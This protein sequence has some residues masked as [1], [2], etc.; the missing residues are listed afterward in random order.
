MAT[1]GVDLGGT[2]IMAVLVDDGE[3]VAKAKKPTPRV[4]GP[5]DVLDA[6][7]DVVATADPDGSGSAIGVGGPGPVVPGSGVLAYAANLPDWKR[8]VDVGGEVAARTGG[9][10]VVVGNDVNVA[11]LAE[12]RSGA[13]QGVEDLM[14]VFVGTGV[15]AGL[16]LGGRLRQGPH[17]L[18]GEIG[19]T[20][21]SFRDFHADGPGR[22]ELEDYAGR[23]SL[24]ERARHLH[25]GGE[26]TVLFELAGEGR[27]KSRVW[28]EAVAAGDAMT[29]RLIDDATEALAAALASAVALVDVQMVVLGGGLADRLGDDFRLDVERRLA[30][31]SFAGVAV[32]V[33]SATLGDTGGALGA[34]LLVEEAAP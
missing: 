12:H 3:I 18:A 9:R 8:P 2:K 23:R 29:R 19:H 20:F 28:G 5:S 24:E 16:I 13:G 17:G 21:V 27:M 32:P 7:A 26:T 34:A 4:G 10:P 33:R 14:A 6:I 15:G 25:L 30:Q 31:R 11:A 22:G 1:I